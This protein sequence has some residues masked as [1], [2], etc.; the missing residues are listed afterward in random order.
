ME[1]AEGQVEIVDLAAGEFDPY[2]STSDVSYDLYTRTTQNSRVT[3]TNN[4]VNALA[5]T[6]FDSK[7]EN[8]FVAHG[9]TNDRNSAV[10]TQIR[11]SIF[12]KNDVNLFIIDWS[13]PA[14]KNY[15]SAKGAT[16]D[17]GKIVGA[18]INS[19][20]TRY[21]V[22]GSKFVLIGHSLG[23]HVV[24]CAGKVVNKEVEHIIGLDPAGPLYSVGTSSNRIDAKDGK[25]VQILHTNGNLLGISSSIGDAD[26]YPNGGNSQPGCG[27]DLTG[28]CSHSRAYEYL[29][30]A[31]SRGEDVFKARLCNSYSAFTG[32]SCNANTLFHMGALRL[33]YK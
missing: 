23:A 4:D 16:V 28:S 18:F 6:N 1:N 33:N 5:N 25:F 14:S 13:G 30:E 26:L 24:G 10:N 19:I 29:A 8:V 21:G 3:I 22:D 17:V 27:I 7:K 32:G 9:W 2:V 11:G 15:I 31:L 12:A 20:Q